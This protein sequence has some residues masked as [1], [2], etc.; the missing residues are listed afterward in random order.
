MLLTSV[1]STPAP[2]CWY[3]GPR[4]TGGT[5]AGDVS[6]PRWVVG[7]WQSDV[8]PL[9]P[10][11][12]ASRLVGQSSTRFSIWEGSSGDGTGTAAGPFP[13]PPALLPASS[14]LPALTF[15]FLFLPQ[16]S[17]TCG[18]G[19]QKRPVHCSNS[20]GAA[21]DPAERPSSETI[22]SLP[23]CQEKPDNADTDWSGSGSSSR[24]I[25]NEIHYIPS[26][27][28]PKFNPLIPNIPESNDVN[29]IPE[30]DFSARKGNVFV[31]DFYYDYNFINF[32]EDLSYY[33]FT[34]KET[35]GE[36]P[37][38][39]LSSNHVEGSRE[40]PADVLH[41]IKPGAAPSEDHPVTSG[42][43]AAAPV[44]GEGDAEPGGLA[45]NDLLSTVPGDAGTATPQYAIPDFMHEE[46]DATLVPRSEDLPPTRSTTSD[47]SANSLDHPLPGEPR[48]AV[49]TRT[50][51]EQG[52]AAS[53][54][55]PW[56][57]HP[58]DLS[59]PLPAGRAGAGVDASDSLGEPGSSGEGRASTEGPGNAGGEERDVA[60]SVGR[61]REGSR[62]MGAV[63]AGDADGAAPKA[64]EQ[65]GWAGMPAGMV[66]THA[67]P[68]DD[69]QVHGTQ[70]ADL[71]LPTPQGPA[72]EMGKGAGST[73]PVVSPFPAG[74]DGGPTGQAGHQLEL[75]T[76]T[77]LSS[78]A[79]VATTASPA[80]VSWSPAVPGPATQLTSSGLPQQDALGPAMHPAGA[81]PS[82]PPSS[83]WTMGVS[84]RPEPAS[85][86]AEQTSHQ[87]PLGSTGPGVRSP[88][89]AP[90]TFAFSDGEHELSQPTPA[91]P[92]LWEKDEMEEEE[93]LLRPSTAMAAN[94]EVGNWS[95]VRVGSH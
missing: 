52:A 27:H 30:E 58:S 59:P 70:R 41:T 60:S 78:A 19:T 83:W 23:R 31:D 43:N 33:P 62:E 45:V 93:A 81:S 92:P 79:L 72:W 65:E 9:L 54:L 91:P 86:R 21:C 32:H 3:R 67:A 39:E 42:A 28:I 7:A 87:A 95:E 64:E 15:A 94:W 68:A 84:P 29:I 82:E 17:A 5:G 40:M 24:E 37:K 48:G 11:P 50:G 74:A 77:S 2:D 89:A 34:E 26:N 4:A 61:G 53:S 12:E 63:I 56:A 18:N 88:W 44:H 1:T 80:A 71:S 20:T 75:H 51:P 76:P 49:P 57:P 90:G 8:E 85:P 25:F 10:V 35:K 55:T 66:G 73:H 22:C 47:D 13:A 6:G 16:C 38:P 36:E 14:A 69:E 46:G